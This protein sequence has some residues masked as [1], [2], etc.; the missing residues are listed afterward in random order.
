[1]AIHQKRQLIHQNPAF[2]WTN[3]PKP[4]LVHQNPAFPWTNRSKRQLVH[5]KRQIRGQTGQN[6]N[7]STKNAILVDEIPDQVGDDGERTE[8]GGAK[9]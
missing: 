1:M 5:Q 4:Q 6:G 3:W 2:P 8:E 9:P 7:L